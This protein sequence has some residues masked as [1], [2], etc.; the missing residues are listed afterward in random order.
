LRTADGNEV[1]RVDPYARQ[2]T[3]SVGNAVVYDPAAFDWAD[4]SFEMPARDDLV[5]YELHVGTFNATGDRQGD[6]DRAARRLPYLRDLGVSAVQVMPPFEFAGDVSWG[7]NPAHLF[8]IE[9]GYGG[10]DAF[11]RFIRAAHE[12]GIAVIVDVV[13]NHLGPSDLDLWRFD[14]WAD[15]DGGGIYFYNDDRARTPWGATRPDY[16]RGEVR[17]FLR[18]SALT[19]LEEFQCDG[20]RF[21][22]T[23]YIRAVD[24][25]AGG[26]LPDGWSFMA[27]VNDEIHA[28]M[29]WKL[30]I[31]EDIQNDPAIVAPTAAGGAGFD[32]QWDAGFL[33][34][35][36]PA[37]E[38][39]DDGERDI[40][41]V[42]AAITGTDRG[43]ALTRVIYTESHD[44]VANDFVRVPEAIAPGDAGSWWSKKRANLGSGLVLTSPGLP[45]LFQ[46]QEL[47][48]DRWF[49]DTV[50]LDWSKEQRFEGMLRLHRDLIQL[51]R[52]VDGAT[53]GLRGANVE[54]LHADA[55]TKVVAFHRWH[56]GGPGDDVVVVVNLAN[57]LADDLRIGFPASGR[58]RVRFNSD[59][60]A[61]SPMFGGHESFDTDADGGPSDGQPHS[62]L[63]S[64]GPYSMVI[65]SRES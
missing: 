47:L 33:R 20:L 17:T 50:A 27:W 32:A 1:W 54:I 26:D 3:S 56:E 38:S 30:T 29:P 58:W 37:L 51:R 59:S 15:G 5:I 60:N 14:G 44:D 57:R 7:Y 36:R 64:V 13:Y 63:V 21:D 53:R 25:D 34:Q 16:G 10:P 6:F 11:K 18:D 28:R 43:A 19:W 22:A 45:M 9:S 24:G 35:I 40:D 52:A 4:H 49:D 55:E 62:A 31:A 42:I 61:Y 2:V 23:V 65:L 46:G 48:E 8:A 12:H 41:A 39:G